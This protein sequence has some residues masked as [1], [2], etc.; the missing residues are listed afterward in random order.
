MI[1]EADQRI[2]DQNYP[3]SREGKPKAITASGHWKSDLLRFNC[4]SDIRVLTT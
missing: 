2:S 1:C 4:N 3:S